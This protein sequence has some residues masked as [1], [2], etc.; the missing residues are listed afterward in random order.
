MQQH[1]GLAASPP[2]RL[3]LEVKQSNEL[4]VGSGHSV[5]ACCF[6]ANVFRFLSISI[7]RACEISTDT[8][9]A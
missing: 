4:G 1:P 2:W 3:I 5:G 8:M 7:G 9:G 6:C